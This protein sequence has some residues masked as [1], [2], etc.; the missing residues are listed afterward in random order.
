ML[1][2]LIFPNEFVEIVSEI[3]RKS[4]N[5]AFDKNDFHICPE[6][7]TWWDELSEHFETSHEEYNYVNLQWC[8]S[9]LG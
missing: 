6:T 1:D 8:H 7:F 9:Q 4:K 5:I 2:I 3:I